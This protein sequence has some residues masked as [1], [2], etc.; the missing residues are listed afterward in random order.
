MRRCL[1]A[2]AIALVTS[3]AGVTPVSADAIAD[4]VED[5]EGAEGYKVRVSAAVALS[6]STDDRAVAALARALRDDRDAAVRRVAALALKKIVSVSTGQK[7]RTAALD[8]LRA[9]RKDKDKKV[10]KAAEKALDALESILATKKPRV[11]VNVDAPTDKTKKAG[12]DAVSELGR[13]VRAQVTRS[14]KE[15]AV[16]WPGTLP[17]GDEL[18]RHGTRAFIVA[19]SVSK[20]TMKK[21]GGRVEV[22]CSVEIRV[23]PWNGS[24][25]KERWTAGQTGKATGSGK[26]TTGTSDRAIA[27]GVVDCVGAVGEQL[28]A[29]KVVPFIKGLASSN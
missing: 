1:I 7:A 26:A 8:A 3:L 27:M 15:Y 18:E 9:A 6:K 20:L 11:F 29:D 24:D 22:A 23:A 14:S 13:V 21:A 10:R 5:L 2:L 28:T 25:G 12:G 19:A 4:N 17:T 16:E